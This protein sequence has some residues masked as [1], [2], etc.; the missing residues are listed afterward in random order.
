MSIRCGRRGEL[1]VGLGLDMTLAAGVDVE[2]EHGAVT[3]GLE[4]ILHAQ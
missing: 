4:E 2:A 3:L 1:E